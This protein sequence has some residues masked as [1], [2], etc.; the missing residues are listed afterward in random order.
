MINTYEV[1]SAAPLS[2][3]YESLTRDRFV[4]PKPLRDRGVFLDLPYSKAQ[5]AIVQT[6]SPIL[7]AGLYP[8]MGWSDQTCRNMGI[9]VTRS[10]SPSFPNEADVI[11]KLSEKWKSTDLN[12][13][14]YFSPEGRES[15]EMMGSTLL[16]IANSARDLKRGNFGS[17]V[18]HLNHMPRSDRRV[19]HRKFEQ[20]DIS[21]S[22]LAM[23]LGWTPLISDIYE[24]SDIKPPVERGV[25]IKAS[26]LGKR[27]PTS[28]A[29]PAS[30][31]RVK[32]V[33][34]EGID[35]RRTTYIGNVR[36]PP[37]FSERF[38]LGNP[39]E[40]AWE[41]VPLSFVADY[42]LPIGNTIKSLYFISQCR[43]DGLWRKQ[44]SET[45]TSVKVPEGGMHVWDM[46]GQVCWN[47]IPLNLIHH[48]TSFT[49]KPHVLSFADPL[50]SINV[51][52]PSSVMKLG[53]LTALAHQRLLNLK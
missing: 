37:T 21:G 6:K 13:G 8:A 25:Q 23:H 38:G 53:T 19:A 17:A 39:F 50:R 29:W 28:L 32:P 43:F 52:L 41:L 31:G 11:A 5:S 12:I 47:T 33:V 48:E 2:T 40:I 46:W 26:K 34:Y 30:A 45:K 35:I 22:F 7:R 3:Y 51:S 20:G 27:V 49:R 36:R 44:Y 18:R 24:A 1:G 4:T 42:F 14:M 9:G 16:R 10:A 15:I